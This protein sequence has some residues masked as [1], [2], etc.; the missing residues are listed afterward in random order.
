[1][2]NNISASE[3]RRVVCSLDDA[4]KLLAPDWTPPTPRFD[5]AREL[6]SV[7][8]HPDG[9]TECAHLGMRAVHWTFCHLHGP[10]LQMSSK[11]LEDTLNKRVCQRSSRPSHLAGKTM[12]DTYFH[13]GRLYLVWRHGE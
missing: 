11:E 7:M 8:C 9:C 1:M 3:E 13:G 4:S 2:L 5:R 12:D 10:L 6:Q